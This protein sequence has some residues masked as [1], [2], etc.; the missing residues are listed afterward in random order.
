MLR[1]SGWRLAFLLLALAGAGLSC[2]SVPPGRVSGAPH[3]DY[4]LTPAQLR[5][6]VLDTFDAMGME[7][8]LSQGN[9]FRTAWVDFNALRIRGLRASHGERVQ[10]RVE[11]RG[12][13][14]QSTALVEARHEIEVRQGIRSE[15]QPHPSRG[16]VE[17][18]F[19]DRLD[20]RCGV[21]K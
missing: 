12:G 13:A 3:R 7:L 10:V 17:E 1:R 14:E 8:A 5:D 2:S 4:R 9:R 16:L 15:W 20:I 18:E 11:I 21:L 6:A 19:L